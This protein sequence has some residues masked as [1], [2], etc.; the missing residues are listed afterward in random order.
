MSFVNAVPGTVLAAAADLAGIGSVISQA[1]AAAAAPTIGAMAPGADEVSVMI[2]ALFGSHAQAYQMIGVQA[3]AFHDQF[4]QILSGGA[5]SYAAAEAENALPLQVVQQGVQAVSQQ[6][7]TTVA[8][9][10]QSVLG[11]PAATAQPAAAAPRVA[12]MVQAPLTQA[13]LT[14]APL[15]QAPL[16]QALAPARVQ[17]GSRSAGG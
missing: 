4:V 7:P 12:P 13:P 10:V 3:A 14:Q 8:T 11:A 15:T 2:A 6:V 16:T 1:N 9:P 17:G 5:N